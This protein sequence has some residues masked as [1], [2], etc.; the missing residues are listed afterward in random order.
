MSGERFCN[1]SLNSRLLYHIFVRFCPPLRFPYTSVGS[2]FTCIDVGLSDVIFI[3]MMSLS[4]R[5]MSLSGRY[6]AIYLKWRPCSSARTR[7]VPI[8]LQIVLSE[9]HD[10]FGF[11]EMCIFVES[12]GNKFYGS[13]KPLVLGKSIIK[14][15][16]LVVISCYF[17]RRCSLTSIPFIKC[18]QVNSQMHSFQLYH[19]CS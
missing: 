13:Q 10:L 14:T 19:N 2:C 7:L 17:I 8:V 9:H 18:Y 5:W 15:L 11:S 12:S 16:C 1:S 3:Y 6:C 4:E